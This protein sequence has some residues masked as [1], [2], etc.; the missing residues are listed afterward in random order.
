MSNESKTT[1]RDLPLPSLTV[2]AHLDALGVDADAALVR[3][4]QHGDSSAFGELV[5]RHDKRVYALI[6][7]ILGPGAPAEDVD[8]VAQDVFV[9]AW[10]ALPR[11]S[12]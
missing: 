2:A 5:G 1:N 7:R 9:Q 3:R 11:F 10:R 6:A 12:Q 4:C 8:D